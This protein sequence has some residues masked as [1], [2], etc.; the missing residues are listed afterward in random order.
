MKVTYELTSTT[1]YNVSQYT[2]D[3]L[4]LYDKIRLMSSLMKD[5]YTEL[6]YSNGVMEKTIYHSFPKGLPEKWLLK[7]TK[8]EITK[9]SAFVYVENEIFSRFKLLKEELISS[10]DAASYYLGTPLW[11]L[12]LLDQDINELEIEDA[13]IKVNDGVTLEYIIDGTTYYFNSEL[14]I[15][16]TTTSNG[17]RDIEKHIT[18]Y[19]R[20]NF[21]H[22]VKDYEVQ[23]SLQ[24]DSSLNDYLETIHSF[25]YENI[26]RE[27][28]DPSL[29]PPIEYPKQEITSCIS[30]SQ[31]GKTVEIKINFEESCPEGDFLIKI[32]DM[33]GNIK[34]TNVM[35][36]KNNPTFFANNF[37]IGIHIITVINQSVPACTFMYIP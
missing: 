14:M 7:P 12:P 31:L 24:F 6:I 19:Q 8:T 18:A 17:E 5:N 35:V 13:I 36:S 26:K 2:K 37:N 30:A 15:Q 9:D 1:S 34:L 23:R 10:K 28:I 33:Q 21:G 22:L 20:D 11:K 16:E 32:T 25:N 29:E 4:K 27:F 3:N